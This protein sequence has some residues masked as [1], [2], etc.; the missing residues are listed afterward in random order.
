MEKRV[1]DGYVI[2][3]NTNDGQRTVIGVLSAETE[4]ASGDIV[5]Q[6]GWKLDRFRKNPVAL[7]DHDHR[8]IL[9]RWVSLG[10]Q[11]VGGVQA[12]VGTL[13]IVP[14]GTSEHADTAWRE[15][16]AGARTGFSVGFKPIES[17]PRGTNGLTF[18]EQELIEVSSV[19]VPSCP[20]CLVSVVKS[21]QDGDTIEIDDIES[22]EALAAYVDEKVRETLHE[23]SRAEIKRM[24]NDELA[25]VLP[26]VLRRAMRGGILEARGKL[27]DVGFGWPHVRR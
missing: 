12:L 13:Q 24:V 27:D 14:E 4:D 26:S 22:A 11:T 16:R 18:L 1:T 10:V 23:T 2:K 25:R 17:E 5:Q 20:D 7:V 3:A 9:G 8:H 6:A 15:I 19:A 21:L